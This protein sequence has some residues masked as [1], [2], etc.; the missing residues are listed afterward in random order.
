MHK[1]LATL[2]PTSRDPISPGP[3]VTAMAERS[4]EVILAFL[5]AV[6]I[7]GM[8]LLWWALEANSGTTPPYCSCTVWLAVMLARILPS[9]SMAA[10]VSSQ[11]LSM[12]KI[13]EGLV[14]GGFSGAVKI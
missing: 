12:P 2:V 10:A 14:F 8:M 1:P 7:T 3:C 5:R 4:D 6:S 9:H 13:M 11:L